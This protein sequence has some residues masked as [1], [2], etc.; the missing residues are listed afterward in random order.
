MPGFNGARDQLPD[1]Y[2]ELNGA[3]FPN[4]EKAVA[5]TIMDE[6]QARNAI[7][8]DLMAEP[9]FDNKTDFY[10][11]VHTTPSGPRK[12]AEYLFGKLRQNGFPARG[13]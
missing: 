2:R 3:D 12:I 5:G 8:F 13:N 10:D 11:P 6:C 9:D 7:R 4:I 1:A